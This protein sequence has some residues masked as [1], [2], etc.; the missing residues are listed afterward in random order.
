MQKTFTYPKFDFVRPP[1]LADGKPGHY[2]VVVVGAGPVG[3]SAAIDLAQLGQDVLTQQLTGMDRIP[4]R[5]HV[6]LLGGSPD[7]RPTRHRP[8]RTGT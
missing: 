6:H 3:L 4:H 5:H 2:P 8:R 1:E 7:S